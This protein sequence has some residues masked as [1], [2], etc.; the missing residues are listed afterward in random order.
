MVGR[1]QNDACLRMPLQLKEGQK[2]DLRFCLFDIGKPTFRNVANQCFPMSIPRP[3]LTLTSNA[4]GYFGLWEISYGRMKPLAHLSA[5]T[6]SVR[7][8]LPSAP[9]CDQGYVILGGVQSR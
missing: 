6:L 3:T 5:G 2:F 4:C 7:H 9:I 8:Q 1:G